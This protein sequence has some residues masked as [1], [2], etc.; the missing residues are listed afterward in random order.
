MKNIVTLPEKEKEN[1]VKII[2]KETELQ[3]SDLKIQMDNDHE[4][5]NYIL[6]HYLLMNI[7]YYRKNNLDQNDWP[8]DDSVV[9]GIEFSKEKIFSLLKDDRKENLKT[10]FSLQ[11]NRKMDEKIVSYPL[12]NMYEYLS[13]NL[14]DLK[15]GNDKQVDFAEKFGLSHMQEIKNIV[16]ILGF[17]SDLKWTTINLPLRTFKS[18]ITELKSLNYNE[19]HI[20][21]QILLSISISLNVENFENLYN[22]VVALG[23]KEKL[24]ITYVKMP[25]RRILLLL[26][27]IKNNYGIPR[28]NNIDGKVI[29]LFITEG[30]IEDIF[31]NNLTYLLK[32]K[33]QVVKN[34]QKTQIKSNIRSLLRGFGYKLEIDVKKNTL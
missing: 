16:E 2:L 12:L 4:G 1:L 22:A 25:T 28:N 31:E 27:Y 19:N 29:N 26:E 11:F 3:E 5:I 9:N 21:N 17:N 30:D 33:N 23:Y 32:D 14:D 13:K 10:E 8:L 18:L 20:G 15:S 6:Y 34:S 7:A 24:G